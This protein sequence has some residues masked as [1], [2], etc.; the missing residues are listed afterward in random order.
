[1]PYQIPVTLNQVSGHILSTLFYLVRSSSSL[2]KVSSACRYATRCG[3]R[4]VRRVPAIEQIRRARESVYLSVD[5]AREPLFVNQSYG[6]FRSLKGSPTYLKASLFERV[7]GELLNLSLDLGLPM[8]TITEAALVAG[9]AQSAVWIPDAY[10]DMFALA[11][12]EFCEYLEG[13]ARLTTG[14]Q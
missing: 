14:A 2:R 7:H 13:R 10:T 8:S 4:V 3:L 11:V 1:M 5:V 6:G 9:L 12:L